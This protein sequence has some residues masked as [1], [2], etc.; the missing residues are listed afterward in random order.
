MRKNGLSHLPRYGCFR[1]KGATEPLELSQ[2]P[3]PGMSPQE[4]PPDLGVLASPQPL[5]AKTQVSGLPPHPHSGR[6]GYSAP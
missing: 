2:S 1:N 3:A 4:N 5:E 6:P